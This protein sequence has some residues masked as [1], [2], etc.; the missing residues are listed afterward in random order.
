MATR[1]WL[2]TVSAVVVQV[3]LAAFTAAVPQPGMVM[4]PSVN[5]TVPVGALPVIVAVNVTLD[6]KVDG[7]GE[8]GERRAA[9]GLIDGLRQ[10]GAH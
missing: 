5:P 8:A 7:L 3:A 6:P 10:R 1:L 2:P 9:C 4:P